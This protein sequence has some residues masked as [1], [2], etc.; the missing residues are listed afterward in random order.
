[1]L[2]EEGHHQKLVFDQRGSYSVL[3]VIVSRQFH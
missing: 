3:R 2:N 1:M